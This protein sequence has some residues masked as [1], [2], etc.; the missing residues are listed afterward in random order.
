MP[1]TYAHDEARFGEVNELSKRYQ[2][3]PGTEVPGVRTKSKYGIRADNTHPLY[4]CEMA[5]E[6][7]VGTVLM[8]KF[9][10]L[11]RGTPVKPGC[12][13]RFTLHIGLRR[14]AAEWTNMHA[15]VIRNGSYPQGYIG[16]LRYT[17]P[18]YNV[19]WGLG[20]CPC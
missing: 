17:S 19:W 10:T 5:V 11:H 13:G 18:G 3:A 20:R 9:D 15:I 7:R 14:A 12:T 2:T 1:R 6:Y 16:T 4:E 8:Y